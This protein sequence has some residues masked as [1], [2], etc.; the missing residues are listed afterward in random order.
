MYF[1]LGFNDHTDARFQLSFRYAFVNP[2][3][4]LASWGRTFRHLYLGYVDLELALKQV[5][6][7]KLAAKLRNGTR[8]GRGS[9]QLDLSFPMDRLLSGSFSAFLHLQYFNGWGET[10]RTYDQRLP[11]RVRI[12]LMIVR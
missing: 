11:S 1:S 8:S 3:G 12:G 6:G 5:N 7:F 9:V 2:S 4:E 10:L